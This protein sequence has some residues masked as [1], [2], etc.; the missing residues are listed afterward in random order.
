MAEES[1][2]D[3]TLGVQ[4]WKGKCLWTRAWR[5]MLQFY[6]GKNCENVFFAY[7]CD[8]LKG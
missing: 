6:I 7:L 5:G 2:V 8:L 1:S 4:H 3:R